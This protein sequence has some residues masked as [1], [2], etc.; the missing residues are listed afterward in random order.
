M[1]AVEVDLGT[2]IVLFR[3]D[4]TATGKSPELSS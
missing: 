2:A 3:L 4:H 1:L